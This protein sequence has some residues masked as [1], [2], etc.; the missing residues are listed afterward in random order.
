MVEDNHQELRVTLTRRVARARWF[1]VASQ[2]RELS[3]RAPTRCPKYSRTSS[4][5]VKITV[6]TFLALITASVI[7]RLILTGGMVQN[8]ALAKWLKRLGAIGRTANAIAFAGAF[9]FILVLVI[10]LMAPSK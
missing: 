10:I 2:Y 7:V 9:M 4:M 3:V 1:L 5:L 8:P 6:L